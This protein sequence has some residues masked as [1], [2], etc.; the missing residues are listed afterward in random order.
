MRISDWSSDVCSSDLDT[1]K[2]VEVVRGPTSSLYGS[3]ALGGTVSFVTKDPSDYLEAGKDA[4]FG[5][6]LGYE[7]SGD[8]LNAGA[9]AAFGGGRWSGMAVVNHRK[10]P[11]NGREAVR[12]QE[13]QGV[14]C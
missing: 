10:G 8:G 11:A 9:P 13:C 1:L 6:R 2:R 3:D 5:L 12:G 7:G 14:E 4:Y